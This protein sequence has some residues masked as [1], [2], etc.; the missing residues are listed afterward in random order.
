M[1]GTHIL[2]S[3]YSVALAMMVPLCAPVTTPTAPASP[4]AL[5][6]LW[7]EPANLA[8][9]DLFRGEW[10]A[11]F[12]PDPNVIYTFVRFK[13]GGA[14][15]GLIVRD[16]SGRE[17]SVKQPIHTDQGDEGPVEVVLSRVLSGI[18]YRQPPV[19]YLRRF[20]V[21]DA[22][23][24]RTVNGGRF[25][26][27]SHG[28]KERSAWSWHANPFSATRPLAGLLVILL[29]FQ[30]S[31][32]K[33]ANNSVFEVRRGDLQERWYVVRDLGAALGETG[34]FAPFRNDVDLFERQRFVLG[35]RGPFVSFA[36][37]GFHQEL[38]RDRIT[39]AD[40]R[41][42]AALLGRLNAGQWADAFRAG[43][44]DPE[45]ADRFIQKLH[46]TID[47]GLSLERR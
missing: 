24:T 1:G 11:G 16:P 27:R 46:A 38:V 9:R 12:A 39:T 15:P 30:S 13:E 20:A 36:Y 43:G 26:L 19:Y 17:W 33:D 6:A 14:N 2:I 4:V 34:R 29:M 23:G 21:T 37:R 45:V 41:W 47:E 31:D 7:Q 35:V 44:Y 22:F 25:R 18:G 28:I 10:E 8:T 32:L 3:L 40:V 5:A 42:A